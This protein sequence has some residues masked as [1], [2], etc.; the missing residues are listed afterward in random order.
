MTASLGNAAGRHLHALAN[1]I[2][3]RAVE[4]DRPVKSVGHEETFAHDHHTHAS[5]EREIV[6]LSDAVGGRLRRHGLAG[7]TVTLKVR[8]SDFHTITRSTTFAGATDST[9][10]ITR[11]AKEL[12]AAVDPTPGVRLIGVSVSG[13]QRRI[14]PPAHPRRRRF[15]GLGRRHRRRWTRSG[16]GSA[17]PRSARP[18]WPI[19]GGLRVRREARMPRGVPATSPSTPRAGAAGSRSVRPS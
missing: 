7:R 6:R 15:A 16:S 10:A 11:G 18:P 2:D 3:E 4:P 8:F 12:L 9:P 5:L 13:L 19:G 1:G 14:G 17:R